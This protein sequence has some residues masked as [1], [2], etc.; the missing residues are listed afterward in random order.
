VRDSQTNNEI[1][2]VNITVNGANYSAPAHLGIMVTDTVLQVT[3]A[4]SGFITENRSVIVSN[5]AGDLKQQ[6]TFNLSPVLVMI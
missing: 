2:G 5:A 3:A 1:D 4:A 6:V